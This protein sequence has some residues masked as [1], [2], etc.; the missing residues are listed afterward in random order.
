M[1]EEKIE[2]QWK[3]LPPE[4][5]PFVLAGLEAQERAAAEK[6]SQE[7]HRRGQAPWKTIFRGQEPLTRSDGTTGLRTYMD[8]SG[9]PARVRH[10]PNLFPREPRYD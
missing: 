7:E 6:A 5:K 10:L 8:P 2:F 4:M 9:S 3:D 1:A